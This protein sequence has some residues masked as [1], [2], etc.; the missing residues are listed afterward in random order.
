MQP[1]SKGRYAVAA[2][3]DLALQGRGRP[4]PLVEIAR[5]QDVSLS[6]LEQLFA[7]LR[8]AGVVRAVR[9]PGGGYL[10]NKDAQGISVAEIVAAVETRYCDT[11]APRVLPD[12]LPERALWQA[13]DRHALE[14]LDRVTLDDVM[15]GKLRPGS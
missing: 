9:G 4:V 6:Y 14:F 2:V 7:H 5:R 8:R 1:G 15:A 10:L 3:L 11:D 12:C 13:F